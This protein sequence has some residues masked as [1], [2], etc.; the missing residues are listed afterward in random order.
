MCNS[1]ASFAPLV[2]NGNTFSVYFSLSFSAYNSLFSLFCFI[3]L[4]SISFTSVY[5]S[6]SL[7][8]SPFLSLFLLSSISLSPLLSS[9]FHISSLFLLSSLLNVHEN[10]ESFEFFY[11]NKIPTFF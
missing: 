7:S 6:L 9:L 10:I 2:Q 5:F 1:C 11:S 8:P 4:V 3:L